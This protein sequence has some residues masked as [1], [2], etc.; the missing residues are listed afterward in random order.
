M[1]IKVSEEAIEQLANRYSDKSK[2][3]RVMING[4]GWGGPVFG[5]VLDEQFE[6]DYI[7]EKNGIKF[8]VNT[9]ILDQ[10]GSFMVDYTSNYFRKGFVVS[11]AYGSGSC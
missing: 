11:T 4:F 10:F 7:E 5:I 2:V 9:D 6:D 8:A 1:S 3:F